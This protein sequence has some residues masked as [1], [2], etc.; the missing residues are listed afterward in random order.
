[1][2]NNGNA[3]KKKSIAAAKAEKKQK[4]SPGFFIGLTACIITG[5]LLVTVA[6]G[7]FYLYHFDFNGTILENV[8]IAGVNVG[9][10]TREEA[11]AAV[12]AA[13]Q[14]TYANT[15]MII[16][17][18]DTQVIITPE[19]SGAKL[20]V[21]AAVWDAY[22][23]GRRGFAGQKQA[24]L[25]ASASEG[26]TVNIIPYLQLDKAAVQEALNAF[27]EHY[28]TTLTQS[29]YEVT[30][31]EDTL[32]LIVH[33][34]I[35][36]YGLNADGLYNDVLNAYSTN[37]FFF[38]GECGM[39]EPDPINL[40]EI[41][42][43]H[44]I[45]PVDA[46][47]NDKFEVVE[48]K[49]GYGFDVAQVQ[50]QL[51][52]AQYGT[53]VEIPFSPIAPAITGEMLQ[54]QL[55]RDVLGNHTASQSSSASRQNNLRLACEAVNGVILL[56]G[57]VFSYN[58]T[59]GERTEEKG[60]KYGASYS[61]GETIMTIGGGICQVSSTLY[62]CALQADLEILVRE[63][64]S[65]APGYVPLGCDATVSWG[66]LD[67][68]FRNNMD[69]PIKIEAS[70]D[71]GSTTISILGTDTRNYYVEMEYVVTA[72]YPYETVYE[73]MKPNNPKG[74]KDGDYI[75][76]PCSGYDVVTY[77][78]KYDKQT[79]ELISKDYEATSKF[80]KRDA[81]ICKIDN[82]TTESTPPASDPS[83]GETQP[84]IGNGGIT[85]E[86]GELPG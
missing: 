68:S 29:T 33:L 73:T 32:L 23:Y 21:T 47:Y 59:L 45:A 1:M 11:T 55:Y 8:Y 54:Q 34:G 70:A 56:P 49:N 63:N 51:A 62:Y 31:Q 41:L 30:G 58:D 16:Q 48:G 17:V 35:P 86:G 9:G 65:Y 66:Y 60:Y 85:D 50:A 20:N 14:D 42:K 19:K 69:Y 43:A 53:T 38:E 82:G 37:T 2:S 22:R 67:F 28:S 71:G 39:I 84:G 4:R 13:T 46:Q 5:L 57:E 75:T 78:C 6:A 81:V 77:R 15:D 44:Y 7:C 10:M 24:D 26:I 61:G 40:D 72:Y 18:L 76:S 74:Y 12:N 64:H 52:E 27:S 80:T 79:N 36:E 83:T 25:D 3:K